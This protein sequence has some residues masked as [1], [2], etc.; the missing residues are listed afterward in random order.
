MEV[1]YGFDL[2]SND[3]TSILSNNSLQATFGNKIDSLIDGVS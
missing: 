1:N 3:T 2:D